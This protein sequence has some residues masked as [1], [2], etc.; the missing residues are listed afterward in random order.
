L[1]NGLALKNSMPDSRP[2]NIP[3]LR[4]SGC[5]TTIGILI[6]IPFAA[7]PVRFA[8]PPHCPPSRDGKVEKIE[9]RLTAT[10]DITGIGF[11]ATYLVPVFDVA[12]GEAS[13]ASRLN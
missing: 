4:A 2:D 7:I 12:T 5:G 9:W 10:A 1:A 6:G 13:G 8:I 3:L 11:R